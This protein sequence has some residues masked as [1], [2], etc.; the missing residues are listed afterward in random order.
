MYAEACELYKKYASS[1]HKLFWDQVDKF[2]DL[3]DS[4]TFLMR[5]MAETVGVTWD[6]FYDACM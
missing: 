6:E 5:A 2:S 1:E 4:C 3:A